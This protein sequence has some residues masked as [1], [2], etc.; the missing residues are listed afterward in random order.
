MISN[1]EVD[2]LLPIDLWEYEIGTMT[3]W[4]TYGWSSQTHGYFEVIESICNITCL[5]ENMETIRLL[6]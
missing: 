3:F 4:P 5:F 6:I 2:D 1:H